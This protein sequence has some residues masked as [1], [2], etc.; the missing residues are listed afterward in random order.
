ME[1]ELCKET[2]TEKEEL[3][4]VNEVTKFELIKEQKEFEVVNGVTAWEIIIDGESLA[5]K[6]AKIAKLVERIHR[7]EENVD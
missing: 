3:E 6:D 4:I 5:A 2:Q 7:A 1:E